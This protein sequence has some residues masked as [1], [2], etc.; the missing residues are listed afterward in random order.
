MDILLI[1]N[2]SPWGSS[3]ATTAM[4]FVQAAHQ[5]GNRVIAIFFNNDGIYN[6]QRGN[7]SDDGLISP[8]DRWCEIGREKNTP[9]LLCPAATARRFD[10]AII[11]K[12]PKEF[13]QAGLVEMWAIA[14]DC[15]RVVTF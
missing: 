3:L 1:V 15:D 10:Q 5:A 14:Q 2:E 11:D 9:L 12:L 8:A 13:R 7:M 6:A 4:R